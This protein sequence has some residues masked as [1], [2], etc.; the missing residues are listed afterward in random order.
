VPTGFA[1]DTE[2]GFS[3]SEELRVV[4][5]AQQLGYESAWTNTGPDAAAF[6]RCLRWYEATGLPVGI[7]AVPASGQPPDFYVHHARRLWDATTG[8]FTIVVGSGQFPHP[9]RE[10]RTYL[11]DVRKGL[12]DGS[13][14]YVAALGPLMLKLAGEVADGVALNWS[15]A[16]L[17]RWS[18]RI[19]TEAATRAGRAIPQVIEYIRTAVDPDVRLARQTVV[20]A[21][22]R[23]T[24]Y[25]PYLRHFERMGV[26]DDLQRMEAS[27]AAATPELVD[28]IGAAGAP[29][30]TRA[31]FERLAGGLDLPIVRV[32]VTRPGDVDSARRVLEEC[33]PRG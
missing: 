32:L 12:P 11:A 4:R 33:R 20:G 9:A 23:Y 7:S 18:R 2:Q 22:V 8:K 24:H 21:A 28:A 14:L 5:L 3:P 16:D 29:G 19:V 15:S 1:L 13:P 31:S 26:A 10:M 27:T 25:P 17:V 6:E 30:G